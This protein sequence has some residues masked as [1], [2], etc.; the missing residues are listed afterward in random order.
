MATDYEGKLAACYIRV[1]TD[2]QEISVDVQ[3]RQ[4]EHY[5]KFKGL[6][7]SPVNIFR[8]PD[9]S[10]RKVMFAKRSGAGA[11]LETLREGHIK[12]L[13]VYK[14]DRL[15][16]DAIDILETFRTLTQKL[17]VTVHFLDLGGDSLSSDSPI[18]KFIVGMMALYAE[19]EVSYTRKRIKDA[20]DQKAI[21]GTNWGTIPYGMMGVPTGKKNKSGG[22]EL[23]LEPNPEEMKWLRMMVNWRM[24]GD[25]TCEGG[26]GYHLIAKRLN[27]VGAPK[28]YRNASR[29]RKDAFG[30]TN[31]HVFKVLHGKIAQKMMAELNQTTKG[32]TQCSDTS[33]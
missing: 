16:R 28:R 21:R 13:I 25:G 32:E 27:E 23:K 26:L 10:G 3:L 19:M 11:L 1:S 9:V 2:Q 7:I 18:T 30:W 15:G 12:H 20:Y 24:H 29:R 5:A 22:P 4:S 6:K 17:G 8:D 31:G 33:T 14:V